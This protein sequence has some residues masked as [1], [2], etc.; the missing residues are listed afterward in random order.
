MTPLQ[1]LGFQYN[2]IG[3][4]KIFYYFLILSLSDFLCSAV[5]QNGRRADF[6]DRRGVRVG[7]RLREEGQDGGARGVDPAAAL[8]RQLHAGRAPA[9][10]YRAAYVKRRCVREGAGCGWGWKVRS[11]WGVGEFPSGGESVWRTR[12][13]RLG[14]GKALAFC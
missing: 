14:F 6:D 13:F 3:C 8:D 7:L 2:V 9:G 1:E 5:T 4:G 12:L 11:R 10:D